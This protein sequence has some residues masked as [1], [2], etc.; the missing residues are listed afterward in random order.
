MS[1]WD[2]VCS[3]GISANLDSECKHVVLGLIF[4][5]YISEAFE[6]R[7]TELLKEKHAS[8]EDRD[9]YV[10]VG[11]LGAQEGPLSASSGQC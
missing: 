9:E 8:P 3:S 1:S 11:L 4:L 10:E 5:K 7:H 2:W 6:E